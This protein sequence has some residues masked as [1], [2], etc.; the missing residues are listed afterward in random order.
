MDPAL[1]VVRTPDGVAP[2]DD[3]ALGP[4]LL[5]RAQADVT[6]PAVLRLAWPRPTLAFSRLDTLGPGWPAAREAARAHGFEP[7]VRQ[8]GGRAAA[9]HEGCLLLDLVSPD[10]DPRTGIR[11]RYE[12]GAAVLVGALAGLGVDARV[13]AVPG[14]YCPG[15]F[16]VNAGGRVKLAGTAQRVVRGAWLFS[17]MLVVR[18]ADRL[19]AVLDDVHAHLGL[20]WDPASVGSV[21]SVLRLDVEGA[22]PRGVPD[23]AVEQAVLAQYAASGH[24]VRPVRWDSALLAEARAQHPRHLPA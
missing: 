2:L 9:Y 14:E 4:A 21:E 13:G 11:P 20:E 19:R 7:V 22:H 6:G 10:A 24:A 23:P 16:S 3:V 5:A 17:S 1:D 8:R 12:A 15:D 18:G